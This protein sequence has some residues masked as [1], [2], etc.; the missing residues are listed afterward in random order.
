[1][2]GNNLPRGLQRVQKTQMLDFSAASAIEQNA[3]TALKKAQ[4]GTFKLQ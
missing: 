2:S 3:A 4:E 1:M